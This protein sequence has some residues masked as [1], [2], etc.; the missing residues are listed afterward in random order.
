M[1]KLQGFSGG[2]ALASRRRAAIATILAVLAGML[3]GLASTPVATAA[4]ANPPQARVYGGKTAP[5][6]STKGFVSLDLGV[7]TGAYAAAEWSCGGTAISERW[8]LTAAHCVR[9]GRKVI[10]LK[11]SVAT[12][13]PG[14]A[15]KSLFE[16]DQVHIF[17]GSQRLHDIALLRTTA[18]M[19]IEPVR[20]DGNRKYLKRGRKLSVMGLGYYR[21]HRIPKKVQ[22]GHMVDRSGASKNCGAYG[23]EYDRKTMLCAGTTN[24]KIDSCQGDS[25]GPLVTRG[26]A[27]VLVGVVSFGYECGSKQYPGVYSRVSRYAKWIAKRT[28]VKPVRLRK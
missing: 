3:V 14:T 27:R 2:N 26:K 24:G 8:I 11:I 20:Y 19:D 12:T 16:L 17:P 21:G 7:K 1:A 23:R 22:I 13:K 6:A 5:S 25:G 28:G 18:D 15:D 10:N 9:E 4:P